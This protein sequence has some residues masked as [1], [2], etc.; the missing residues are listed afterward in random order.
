MTTGGRQ[1]GSGYAQGQ[2]RVNP[3]FAVSPYE[4]IAATLIGTDLIAILP[5][6]IY[7]R[8]L[9]GINIVGPSSA[10]LCEIFLGNPT[11]KIDATNKV[12]ATTLTYPN[13]Y[14]LPPNTQVWVIWR[15]ASAISSIA[16][17]LLDTTIGMAQTAAQNVVTPVTQVG[18]TLYCCHYDAFLNANGESVNMTAPSGTIGPGLWVN[19]ATT[20][21]GAGFGGHRLWRAVCT[22]AAAHTVTTNQ[23]DNASSNG[24]M[25]IR[26][27]GVTQDS[28]S[29][30]QFKFPVDGNHIAPD[31]TFQMFTNDFLIRAYG[32]NVG[33][34]P[35]AL[36][37]NTPV[38]YSLL[39]QQKRLTN[40]DQAAYGK[41]VLAGAMSPGSQIAV[42]DNTGVDSYETM[43]L[44]VRGVAASV[45]TPG[46][47]TFQLG[48][49][50]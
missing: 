27:R 4:T 1:A 38:G 16:P 5:A 50:F 46:T 36:N 33:G 28:A 3:A 40:D 14:S 8:V 25:T 2:Y 42:N 23:V 11:N 20:A 45:S 17:I 7:P 6:S 15:N 41:L 34:A 10:T 30:T 26:M 44:I 43:S 31:I 24:N 19:L 49:G 22:S 37:Y 47:V 35:A 13:G 18:D 32:C 9:L 39:G 48:P 21:N 12:D 29:A